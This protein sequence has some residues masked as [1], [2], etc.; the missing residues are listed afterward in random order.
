MP[1]KNL[2]DQNPDGTLIGASVNEK[3][4]LYGG[5]PVPQRS[6][7]Q[8]APIQGFQMGQCITFVS[9]TCPLAN[10]APST[11]AEQ[12]NLTM[13]RILATD[14]LVGVNK[15]AQQA[16][17]GVCGARI[18]AA[19]TVGLNFSNPSTANANITA[20]EISWSAVVL[21]G[22][23]V[24][25]A[26]LVPT[27]VP[28]NSTSEQIFN[29]GG[30]GAT[31]TATIN[32]DGTL[33]DIRV[34]NAGS[35]YTV[36][37]MVFI[38][39]VANAAYL[40]VAENATPVLSGT[41]QSLPVATTGFGASAV[42]VV[43]NG[44]VSSVVITD[45]GT[46]YT[47]AP[48]ISFG[49]PSYIAPGM[50]LSVT[51]PTAQAGLGIGNVRIPG[52][53]Q[54]AIQ[55]FNNT[56][57]NITP[58][59]NENYTM[60]ALNEIPAISPFITIQA[61]YTGFA[62]TGVNGATN[63]TALAVPGLLASDIPFGGGPVVQTVAA[64]TGAFWNG[65]CTANT[66]NVAYSAGG[67]A[68]WTPVAG[69]YNYPIMRQQPAA[70]IQIFTQLITPTSVAALSA[71]EQTFTLTNGNVLSSTTNTNVIL[72]NKPS[73]TPYISIIGTRQASNTTVGINFQ[74]CN[75]TTAITPPAEV[76]TFAYFPSPIGTISA[77]M[78]FE[79]TIHSCGITFNTLIDLANELQQAAALLGVI[80]GT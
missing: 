32:T 21:R 77:N 57:A 38:T 29:V 2:T 64:N 10:V 8:Q 72:C 26:T 35:L 4:G 78:L 46:G 44:G 40:G 51:K 66:L 45:P 43:A 3:L 17:V 20:N 1:I 63:L 30:S 48:T 7:P 39:P 76:Y 16:N 24:Q 55:F 65:N 74:N 25:T 50:F 13:E 18:S 47:V 33:K 71:A 73:N 14:Y 42:A 12:A 28:A 6:N 60:I 75:T 54:I 19:N 49:A 22:M 79:N 41:M 56:A 61:N 69:V 52:K 80:K 31:A 15:L 27:V 34:S 58:T 23:N 59:A 37:P 70:P 67:P 53:N 11:T 68:T 9:N 36:P 5:I 62:A